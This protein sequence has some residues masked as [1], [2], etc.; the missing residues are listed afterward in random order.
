VKNNEYLP[1]GQT[2]EWKRELSDHLCIFV[3]F[4]STTGAAAA[5]PFSRSFAGCRPG[6]KGRIFEIP[7]RRYGRRFG[8]KQGLATITHRLCHLIWKMLHG[9]MRYEELGPEVKRKSQQGRAQ[10]MIRS[11]PGGRF[12]PRIFDLAPTIHPF[13]RVGAIEKETQ[14][15]WTFGFAP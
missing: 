8:H 10:K 7:Y 2:D 4:E 1:N 15:E 14:D 5:K 9:G 12:S 11:N 3:W 13:N 6:R